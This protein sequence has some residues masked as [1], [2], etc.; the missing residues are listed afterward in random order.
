MENLTFL[1]K[2][3]NK[4]ILVAPLNWGLGHVSRVS[5]LITHLQTNNEIYLASDG[6]ALE[7]LAREFPQINAIQLPS[8]G[9]QYKHNTM[10]INILLTSPQLMRA[11]LQEKAIVRELVKNLNIDLIIS[12]HRLGC[13]SDIC[14][15]IVVA[16]QLHIP[17]RHPSLSWIASHI[18]RY[19]LN[20]YDEVWIPDYQSPE[21]SL[22]G[23]LSEPKGIKKYRH[24]GALT[25]MKGIPNNHKN[26]IDICF[27]LSGPEPSRT[28]FELKLIEYALNQPGRAMVLIRG[29]H[30]PRLEHVDYLQF[31]EVID[32]ASQEQVN[33]RLLR[34]KYVVCRPGYTTIMDLHKLEK[35][36]IYVPTPGQPEQNYLAEYHL[37]KGHHQ[38]PQSNISGLHELI[39]SE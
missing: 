36:A 34:S 11:V 3:R 6:L 23:K 20:K 38:L 7:W 21:L 8:Y 39:V 25:R 19:Y 31:Q 5:V 15:S 2:Y 33:Q 35:Q 27:L 32:I 14:E 10:W 1:K 24:I 18:N 29:T 17:F 9:V 26:D 4:R 37:S 30:K 16:H 13:Y 28:Q 12:D 22:S